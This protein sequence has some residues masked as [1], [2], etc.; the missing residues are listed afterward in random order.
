MYILVPSWKLRFVGL[1][2]FSPLLILIKCWESLLWENIM[3]VRSDFFS[4]WHTSILSSPMSNP[5][6]LKILQTVCCVSNPSTR[7][8]LVCLSVTSRHSHRKDWTLALHCLSVFSSYFW[9]FRFTL[10]T[11]WT[12]DSTLLKLLL[13]SFICFCHQ[14]AYSGIRMILHF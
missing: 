9:R 2:R 12:W 14:R 10:F 1:R 3:I 11:I 5:M 13:R 8:V 7:K 4:Q 6:P